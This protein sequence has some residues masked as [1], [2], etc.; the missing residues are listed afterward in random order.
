MN[1]EQEMQV[2]L[3]FVL[4]WFLYFCL[5]SA[6]DAGKVNAVCTRKDQI[7]FYS[8]YLHRKKN[9]FILLAKIHYAGLVETDLKLPTSMKDGV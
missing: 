4:I 6:D 3:G 1:V 8:Q 2:V 5:Y 9:N 7:F